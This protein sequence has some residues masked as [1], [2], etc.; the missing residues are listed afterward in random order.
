MTRLDHGL[1]NVPLSKRGNIDAEIDRYKADRAREIKEADRANF[2]AVRE[3]QDAIRGHL[4]RIG[5]HRIMMLAKPLGCRKPS[6]AREALYRAARSNLAVWLAALERESI[7]AG[8]C[9]K[10]WA[11][12]GQCD[13][14]SDEWL[15]A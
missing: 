12:L 13:H 4:E 6:T 5:D 15:G 9:A 1:L 8:G 2:Y 7:P 14:S 3:R 11:P 10:C